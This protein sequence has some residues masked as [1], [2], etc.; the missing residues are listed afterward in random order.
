[1]LRVLG[2]IV[3][4]RQV[5]LNLLGN[6]IKFT[7]R[8]YVGLVVERA[9][10]GLVRFVVADTGPGLDAGQ[11]AR[12]FRRCGQVGAAREAPGHGGS[13]LG[14]AICQELVVGMGGRIGVDSV[15]GEGTRFEVELPLPATSATAPG[16]AAPP[17]PLSLLLVED[18]PSAAEI[19]GGLLRRDGHTVTH[20]AHGLAALTALADSTPD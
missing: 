15:P 17:P 2:D 6:A 16:V 10:E 13:G 8:G 9:G 3:R 4:V 12:I 5:L 18:N 1:P 20:A 7:E 14:L 19:I 11:R